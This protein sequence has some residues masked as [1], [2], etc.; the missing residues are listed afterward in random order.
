MENISRAQNAD[1]ADEYPKAVEH[2]VSGVSF[3]RGTPRQHHG[4]C[5]VE[6]PD[7]HERA[8]RSQPTDKAEAKYPH[9]HA[10]H[11]NGFNVAKDK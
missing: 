5:G 1:D 8:V 4:V 6:N 10:N 9:Q 11:F 3:E 7:E 2:N